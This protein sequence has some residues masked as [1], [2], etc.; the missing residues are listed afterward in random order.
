MNLLD[1]DGKRNIENLH[2][3]IENHNFALVDYI[4]FENDNRSIIQVCDTGATSSD[5]YVMFE[6]YSVMA[7]FYFLKSNGHLKKKPTND[8]IWRVSVEDFRAYMPDNYTEED[9]TKVIEQAK[10]HFSI[11]DYHEHIQIFIDLVLDND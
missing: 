1:K 10:A 4:V 3:L 2:Q 6:T 7:A 8:T 11:V 5:D 9:F